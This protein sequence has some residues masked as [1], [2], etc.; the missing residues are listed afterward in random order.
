MMT[1]S[2]VK[3][4]PVRI[5]QFVPTEPVLKM[6][7]VKKEN[8]PVKPMTPQNRSLGNQ[9]VSK[10][11]GS[12]RVPLTFVFPNDEPPVSRPV[13]NKK[14]LTLTKL[15]FERVPSPRVQLVPSP[16][17]RASPTVQVQNLQKRLQ[18]ALQEIDHEK[19]LRLKALSERELL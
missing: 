19:T 2:P 12:A 7:P 16:S 3:N 8:R 14:N 5:T 4:D 6:K 11:P 13:R 10:R 17:N 1:G 15:A 18:Q 9:P